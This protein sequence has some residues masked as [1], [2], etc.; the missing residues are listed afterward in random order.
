MVSLLGPGDQPGRLVQVDGGGEPGKADDFA[1]KPLR[2]AAAGCDP[3]RPGG[4]GWPPIVE[5]VTIAFPHS[6]LLAIGR[7]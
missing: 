1:G 7:M 3:A 2:D 6:A 4:P 5:D